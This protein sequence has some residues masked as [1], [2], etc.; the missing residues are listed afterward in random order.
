MVSGN[1]LGR[2]FR[3]SQTSAD[4]LIADLY[5][6]LEGL[7]VIRSL[8]L[9][10]LIDQCFFVLCLNHFL[11]DSFAIVKELLMFDII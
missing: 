9:Y 10:Q 4:L 3:A 2:F 6:H 1:L 8:F 7:V 11:Q 5:A